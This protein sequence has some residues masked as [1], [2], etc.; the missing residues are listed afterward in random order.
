MAAWVRRPRAI[1]QG[2][3]GLARGSTE[4]YQ[5]RLVYP[6]PSRRNTT[7]S[8]SIDAVIRELEAKSRQLEKDRD[9]QV[10]LDRSRSRLLSSID[11]AGGLEVEDGE[12]YAGFVHRWAPI[13]L[14]VGKLLRLLHGPE[15]LKQLDLSSDPVY[16]ICVELLERA[17]WTVDRAKFEEDLVKAVDGLLRAKSAMSLRLFFPRLR[18][19]LIGYWARVQEKTEAKDAQATSTAPAQAVPHVP[20]SA[21]KKKLYPSQEAA[22]QLSR[23]AF[24]KDPDLKEGT[25]RGLY[26]WLKTRPDCPSRLPGEASFLRNLS[27]GRSFH[28]GRKRDPRKWNASPSAMTGNGARADPGDTDVPD[29]TG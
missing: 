21:G 7:M 25:D 24:E 1:C 3:P 16:A 20:A 6:L 12:S 2:R 23:W 4:H 29:S 28:G 27:A 13:W 10:D 8:D 18:S 5:C 9:Q 22:Y 26:N 15:A 17:F 14:R 19:E 11:R